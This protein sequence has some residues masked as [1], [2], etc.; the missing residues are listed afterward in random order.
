[1][2][3]GLLSLLAFAHPRNSNVAVLGFA[4]EQIDAAIVRLQV[5]AEDSVPAS[6]VSEDRLALEELGYCAVVLKGPHGFRHA[7]AFDR[8]NQLRVSEDGS[9]VIN[10][11]KAALKNAE[12]AV[13]W[14]TSVKGYVEW[15]EHVADAARE[16]RRPP[17]RDNLHFDK[18]QCAVDW[19]ESLN[20]EEYFHNWKLRAH[21]RAAV[22]AAPSEKQVA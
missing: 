17:V 4:K 11:P 9:R 22:S 6:D 15:L 8:G 5:A 19:L 7:Q 21:E 1:M 20:G 18:V 14:L 3:R 16:E 13:L 10:T 12:D 2:R